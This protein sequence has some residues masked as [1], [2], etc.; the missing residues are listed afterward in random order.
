M[1]IYVLSL[2][3]VSYIGSNKNQGYDLGLKQQY[4]SYD[5]QQLF[6]STMKTVSV[7]NS[8]D[9]SDQKAGLQ[10]M[11]LSEHITSVAANAIMVGAIIT[12]AV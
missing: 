11:S 10:L 3:L 9:M 12:T 7:C 4:C 1:Y 5:R 6:S 2:V 8:C